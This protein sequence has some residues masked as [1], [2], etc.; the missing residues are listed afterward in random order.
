MRKQEAHF[1][2]LGGESE[3][4]EMKTRG[5]VVVDNKNAKVE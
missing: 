1:S 4:W 2:K 5:A 3:A